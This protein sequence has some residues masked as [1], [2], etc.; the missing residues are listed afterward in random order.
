MKEA[1]PIRLPFGLNGVVRTRT[2]FVRQIFSFRKNKTELIQA[3]IIYF[4]SLKT[5][6]EFHIFRS[7]HEEWSVDP[8]GS[9]RLNHELLFAIQNE[10]LK[11]ERKILEKQSSVKNKS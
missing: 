7:E 9:V 4:N 8:E 10:I 5:D 3:Y 11:R 2:V 1:F 6:I